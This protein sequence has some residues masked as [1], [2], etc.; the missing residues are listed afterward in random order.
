M[1]CWE[2]KKLAPKIVEAKEEN[3]SKSSR[4]HINPN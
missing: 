3:I 2:E 4:I 1:F